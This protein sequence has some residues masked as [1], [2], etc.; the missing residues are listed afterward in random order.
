MEGSYRMEQLKGRELH[1]YLPPSYHHGECSY[2]VM[3]LQ[4]AGEVMQQGLNFLEHLMLTGQLPELILIGI[5]PHERR[6]EYTPWPAPPILSG[7]KGFAGQGESYLEELVHVIKPYMDASFRTIP[8]AKHTGIGGC[9]LGGLI[10]LYAYYQYPDV[11]GRLAWLSTSFWY[12]KLI[13]YIHEQ[14]LPEGEHR[15]Y[16]YVGELEGIYKT[17]IQR[18]MVSSTK[19]AYQLLSQKGL[20]SHQLK[21]ETDPM[22]THDDIFF[23]RYFPEALKWLFRAEQLQGGDSNAD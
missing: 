21:F 15:I 1:I 6:D 11:F 9:S 4:D 22:G 2:P 18:Q 5:Q 3:Y 19:E 23:G 20:S 14:P 16:M 10:S 12:E 13:S 7:G 8:D 17:N